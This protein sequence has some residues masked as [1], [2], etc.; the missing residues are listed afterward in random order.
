MHISLFLFPSTTPPTKL[1][2][3]SSGSGAGRHGNCGNP[4][5]G[6]LTNSYAAERD[7][8]IAG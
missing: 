4:T 1:P 5:G 3:G 7:A 8:A 2:F 6:R